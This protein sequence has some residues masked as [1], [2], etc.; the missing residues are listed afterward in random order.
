[1]TNLAPTLSSLM[2]SDRRKDNVMAHPRNAWCKRQSKG[3]SGSWS[4]NWRSRPTH[5]SPL[6]SP[7]QF[8][9]N[10]I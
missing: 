3:V 9:G 1:M 8:L 10:A 7:R 4:T 5:W 2:L 6:H